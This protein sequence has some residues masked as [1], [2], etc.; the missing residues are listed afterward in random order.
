MYRK[1]V[2]SGI[3]AG[4]VSAVLWANPA[5]SQVCVDTDGDG[6]G[7]DGSGSCL[8]VEEQSVA[9]SAACVDPDGDG[10]GWD[11]QATCLIGQSVQ[12][13]SPTQQ[14]EPVAATCID[15]DGDGW[16]WNGVESCLVGATPQAPATATPVVNQPTVT[17][18]ADESLSGFNRQRDLVAIHFDH[19]PDRDDGH[20]AVASL[21][22]TQKLGLNVQVVAGTYGEYSRDRYVPASESLMASVWGSN[23]LNAH[24][25]REAS[26]GA[27]V[28]RWA[29]VLASGGDVWVAEGGPSDF[30]AEVV[31]RINVQH[32][33]FNTR[34]RIHVIQHSGWNED[35]ALA[36][37]LAYVRNNTRYLQI[38]DGNHPNATADLRFESHNNGAFVSRAL[39][40]NYSSEWGVAFAYLSPSEKLDFSDAVE[41][42]YI[43]GIGTNEIANV[44][45]FGDY[46]F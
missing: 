29:S 35:H 26:I 16:G 18:Q 22:V 43:V 6:W 5:F 30:T 10:Y 11:G 31:R 25:N 8:I 40:S 27:A 17:P 41:L 33:E 20:A 2:A 32:T 44:N 39:S 21:M 4:I 13:T 23:W 15:P 46:F 37:A 38:D 42:L 1:K 9:T 14:A 36:S 24:S 28:N 45:Q 34:N 7:W 12:T 19:A 3:F